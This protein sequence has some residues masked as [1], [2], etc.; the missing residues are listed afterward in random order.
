MP[1]KTRSLEA[2]NTITQTKPQGAKSIGYRIFTIRTLE[3]YTEEQ[4]EC[5]KQRCRD[6]SMARSPLYTK[7]D[8]KHI[9]VLSLQYTRK[10]HKNAIE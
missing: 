8:H 4:F 9:E 6:N 10:P 3:V 5:Y 1:K 2:F 7:R